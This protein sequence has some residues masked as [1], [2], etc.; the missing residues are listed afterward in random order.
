MKKK[1]NIRKKIVIAIIL[2]AL[3]TII[4]LLCFLLFSKDSYLCL[5][6]YYCFFQPIYSETAQERSINIL[7][8]K[9]DTEKL[10]SADCKELG[11]YFSILGAHKISAHY[12]SDA[13]YK[14][15][16]QSLLKDIAI[17]ELALLKPIE[18]LITI[19]KTTDNSVKNEYFH[20]VYGHILYSNDKYQEAYKAYNYCINGNSNKSVLTYSL[21]MAYLASLQFEGNNEIDFNKK[22]K[23]IDINDWPYAILL[24]FQDKIS[25]KDLMDIIE[26]ENH[27]IRLGES[28]FYL[29]EYYRIKGKQR[30]AKD[31]FKACISMRLD[32]YVEDGLAKLRLLQLIEQ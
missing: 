30:K 16:D 13:F 26:K 4:C 29:G 6:D 8:T 24:F 21:L 11:L 3:A 5:K 15:G 1:T 23:D 7:D 19:E 18:S 25:R 31:H 32:S 17:E 12:F 2:S 9:Y 14:T 27:L 22:Y 20:R 28:Y 10:S